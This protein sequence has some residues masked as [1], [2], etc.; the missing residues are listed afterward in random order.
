MQDEAD[1]A[2]V[3]EIVEWLEKAAH[4]TDLERI[5]NSFIKGI[6]P[7]ADSLDPKPIVTF[8]ILLNFDG[9]ELE[10][11][12]Y[13]TMHPVAAFKDKTRLN[14]EELTLLKEFVETVPDSTIKIGFETDETG[15]WLC[16]HQLNY[17]PKD[18]RKETLE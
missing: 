12:E 11:V 17:I 6:V 1:E 10:M 14:K 4:D 9:K 5:A 18:R 16:L 2:R 15:E 8:Q 3:M 7:V 13:V